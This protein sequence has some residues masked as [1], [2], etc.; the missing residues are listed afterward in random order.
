MIGVLPLAI[1]VSFSLSA[2]LLDL[3]AGRRWAKFASYAGMAAALA[4]EFFMWGRRGTYM[5]GLLVQDSMGIVAGVLI[6]I[7][8]LLTLLITDGYDL[9]LNI[10]EGEIYILLAL[11]TAG[12]LVMVTTRHLLVA[13]LGMEILSVANYALAG[14]R[15][16]ELSREASV[17]YA[18]L[19][20]MAS[21]FFVMGM[22]FYYA[23]GGSFFLDPRV[24]ANPSPLAL[25]AGLLLL[26][27]LMFK[28]SLFPFHFWTPDVYQGSPTPVTA[29]FSVVTKTAGFLMLLRI[30]DFVIHPGVK[31]FILGSSVLSML[32]GN[33]VALKQENIKRLMA[34][35][36]IS[37]AGYM[38][39]GLLLGKAGAWA[40]L[41]YLAAYGFMNLGAFAVIS[42][43]LEKNSLKDF[44]GLSRKYPYLS[45]FLAFFMVSLAGFPPT[46]GFLAKFL[47][48]AEVG[49]A[50]FWPLVVVAVLTTLVSVYYYLRVVLVSYMKE[51]P[52]IG[53][54][55]STGILAMFTSTFLVLELGIFPST[56][57]VF[58]KYF[59][60]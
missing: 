3:W 19:G 11:S 8:A 12:A 54:Y 49:D 31:W 18:I 36:S 35:S 7:F 56:L 23:A 20:V 42:S 38:A 48:F 13:F 16:D 41:F 6:L 37:H 51:G 22:A 58:L 34:Y 5:G 26:S 59:V 14:M 21:V 39:M 9:K 60:G 44:Q 27:S 45:A 28:V 57:L 43:F 30:S 47:L 25:G 46:A 17:K 1:L 2:L 24:A 50:G 15:K 32:Y 40:L 10:R 53:Y 55:Y 4:A 33:L 29:F 52:G